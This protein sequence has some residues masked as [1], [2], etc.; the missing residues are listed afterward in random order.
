MKYQLGK[1]EL[2]TLESAGS[3]EAIIVRDG[4]VWLT[5]SDDTRDYCLEA[6]ARLAVSGPCTLIVEALQ[7]ST[8]V[9]CCKESRAALHVT[10][11]L[12]QLPDGA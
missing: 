1:G 8:L 11:A 12:Q 2:L 7:P 5:R 4:E 3:V 6:G 9:L 10:M